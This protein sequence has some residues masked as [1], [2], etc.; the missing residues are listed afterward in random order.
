M[1]LCSCNVIS[2]GA[3]RRSLAAPNPPRTPSQVHRHLGC[4]AQCGRCARSLRQII[5]EAG[6][7]SA[8]SETLAAKVA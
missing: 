2:D 8:A 5:D 1:I 4:T 3:V 7:T 6:P